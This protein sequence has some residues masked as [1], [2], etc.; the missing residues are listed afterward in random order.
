MTAKPSAPTVCRMSLVTTVPSRAF[1]Q[2]WVGECGA[3]WPPLPVRVTD[4]Y[5]R[6]AIEAANAS[7]EAQ[8]GRRDPAGHT[9]HPSVGRFL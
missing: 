8:A 1:P 2:T 6:D 3:R 4:S 5:R 7:L 9:Q